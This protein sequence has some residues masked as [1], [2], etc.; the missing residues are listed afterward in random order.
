MV[1][2]SRS[3]KT[4]GSSVTGASQSPKPDR[5]RQ[6][7]GQHQTASISLALLSAAVSTLAM[8]SL[9]ASSTCF[10]ARFW[11]SSDSPWSLVKL[12]IAF[13][14]H[15]EHFAPIPELLHRACPLA[16]N[17][18]QRSADGGTFTRMTSPSTMPLSPKSEFWMAFRISCLIDP[19]Y[20]LITIC[21]VSGTLTT[22]TDRMSWRLPTLRL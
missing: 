2:S 18:F 10:S 9:V 21:V 13:K 15:G 4:T 1:K 8:A 22:A 6:A 17:C 20:G 14:C 5:G 16:A 3:T 19:S 12:P 7:Q 11:S